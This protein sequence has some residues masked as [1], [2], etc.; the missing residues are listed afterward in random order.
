MTIYSIIALA[1]KIPFGFI[2]NKAV[3]LID[4]DDIAIFA[5]GDSVFHSIES[6]K[7]LASEG[8][9]AAVINVS[10]IKPIDKKTII[11]YAKK[12][13]GILS[14]E[15]ASVIGGLG[16]SICDVIAE[17]GLGIKVKKIGISLSNC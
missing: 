10:T 13:K 17:A 11:N 3:P 9:N 4:G 6:A 5:T 2:V 14:V 12:T 16:S 15:D 1:F 7:Q 8:I